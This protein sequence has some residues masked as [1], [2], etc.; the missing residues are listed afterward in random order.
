MADKYIIGKDRLVFKKKAFPNKEDS[1]TVQLRI[2]REYYNDIK[3]IADETGE[4]TRKVA[5]A[6]IRFAA[7]HVA[8]EEV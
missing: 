8:I 4:P 5:E 7:L 1:K 2:G 3:R 6:L